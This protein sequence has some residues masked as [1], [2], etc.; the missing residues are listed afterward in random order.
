MSKKRKGLSA[1]EKRDVILNIYHTNKDVYNLKE[2][3]QLGSKAGVVQ[4]TVYKLPTSNVI[5][6]L[7]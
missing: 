6:I 5:G 7:D 3:E 4:Q 1:D 2:I